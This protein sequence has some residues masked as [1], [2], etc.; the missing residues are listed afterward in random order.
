MA[1]SSLTRRDFSAVEFRI[2]AAR[3]LLAFV[4]M[5]PFCLT[6]CA[7][8]VNGR[9]Q[10]LSI[11]SNPPG[12]TFEVDGFT[13]TTPSTVKVKRS[14]SYHKVAIQMP[15]YQPTEQTVGRRWSPWV[16]GNIL[17][18]GI[19][20]ILLDVGTGGAFALQSDHI[21]ADLQPLYGDNSSARDTM[22]SQQAAHHR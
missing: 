18:G 4:G 16:A 5:I 6:G 17:I 15:G 9:H 14:S 1:I 11:N 19:P 8:V 20:G 2:S 22:N 12:A 13:G 3:I 7:T 21:Q 10:A